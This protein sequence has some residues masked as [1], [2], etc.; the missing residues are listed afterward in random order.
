MS[1]KIQNR[2]AFVQKRPHFV[3]HQ[4]AARARSHDSLKAKTARAPQDVTQRPITPPKLKFME[5]PL[6]DE[7]GQP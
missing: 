7:E 3:D 1:R 2:P 4:A 6:E 5:L